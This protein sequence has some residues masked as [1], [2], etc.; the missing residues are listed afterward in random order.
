MIEQ[1]LPRGEDKILEG[2]NPEIPLG[3]DESCL[4]RGELEDAAKRYQMINIKLDKTGGL[5][6][7]LL[8]VKEIQS[9][10]L[11]IMVGNMGGTS[12]AMAPGFVVAQMCQLV[13]LDGP[14]C[15]TFDRLNG[16][17]YV[18]DK[19]ELSNNLIWG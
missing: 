12:L 9:K 4:H 18:G 19:I 5:T 17:P 6:E 11:D 14:S 2:L 1:P 7:A 13:D 15:I 3:A 16:L 8:L 10:G